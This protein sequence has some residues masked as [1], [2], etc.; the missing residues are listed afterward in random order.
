MSSIMARPAMPGEKSWEKQLTPLELWV[1]ERTPLELWVPETN[2]ER[3]AA[4]QVAAVDIVDELVRE[5]RET[6]ADGPVDAVLTGG[7][8]TAASLLGAWAV[9]L[10]LL[11]DAPW[12]VRA[13][14]G[15]VGVVV[16]LLVGATAIVAGRDG[17][18]R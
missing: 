14:A 2:P 3:E 1:L 4:R 6:V 9:A 10:V 16:A 8:V 15:V 13:A 18:A 7:I 5:Y 12:Q 17:G 11:Q